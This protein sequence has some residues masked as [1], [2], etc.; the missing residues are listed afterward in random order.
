VLPVFIHQIIEACIVIVANIYISIFLGQ[1][2]INEAGKTSQIYYLFHFFA[3]AIFVGG[4]IFLSQYLGKG[5]HNKVKEIS[6]SLL[7]ITLSITLIF[8]IILYFYAAEILK[9]MYRTENV[10]ESNFEGKF[11]KLNSITL[12]MAGVSIVLSELFFTTGY[13]FIPLIIS[14]TSLILNII[15][16]P[17]F[18]N[19]VP[20]MSSN[21][22]ELQG[23]GFATILS[24]TIEIISF[25]IILYIKKPVFMPG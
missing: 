1:D 24:R 13:L 17:I 20:Q 4:N 18:M 5:D 9:F 14:G 25:S 16:I 21:F 10:N 3:V 12:P 7:I 23:V 8:S 11:L 15:F 19:I 6:R 22:S 2:A